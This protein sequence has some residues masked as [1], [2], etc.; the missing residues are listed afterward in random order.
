MQRLAAYVDGVN[1]VR[2]ETLVAGLI[3]DGLVE[4]RGQLV[5]LS[6]D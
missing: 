5:R 1:A 2:T 6:G 4:R 3:A